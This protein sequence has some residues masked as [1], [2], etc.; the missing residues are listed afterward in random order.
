MPRPAI[1]VD[2]YRDALPA[3]AKSWTCF[4]ALNKATGEGESRL[5]WDALP[6]FHSGCH[7]RRTVQFLSLSHAFQPAGAGH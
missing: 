3:E 7:C 1:A 5:G 2:V 4:G 6:P